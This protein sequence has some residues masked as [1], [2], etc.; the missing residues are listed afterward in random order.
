IATV[1]VDVLLGSSLY[2]AARSAG[3]RP[4][5]VTNGVMRLFTSVTTRALQVNRPPLHTA[6]WCSC[7]MLASSCSSILLLVSSSM[8]A[9]LARTSTPA[10]MGKTDL[11]ASTVRVIRIART[12]HDDAPAR[13]G[14]TPL[15]SPGAEI[16]IPTDRRKAL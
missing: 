9:Q 5:G 1:A 3:P 6:L 10:A 8:G 15:F 14:I 16:S 11:R 4:A 12:S 13:A 2:A 7:G